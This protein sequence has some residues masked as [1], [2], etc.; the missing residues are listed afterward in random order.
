MLVGAA[1]RSVHMLSAG[2]PGIILRTPL[3]FEGR[4]LV[5]SLPKDLA[6]LNGERLRKRFGVVGELLERQAEIRVLAK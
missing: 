4:K 3:S 1:I 5:L 2:A 6:V